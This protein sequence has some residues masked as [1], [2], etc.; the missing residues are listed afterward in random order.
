MQ[1]P[2][3]FSPFGILLGFAG[4]ALQLPELLAIKGRG[5]V[6]E[7]SMT[8]ASAS[9]TFSAQISAGVSFDC[10]GAGASRACSCLSIAG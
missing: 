8:Y 10:D 1:S 6:E 4:F 7:D 2:P 5:Q 3:Y 9:N